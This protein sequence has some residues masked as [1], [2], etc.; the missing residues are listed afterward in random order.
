MLPALVRS[1]SSRLATRVLPILV[2]LGALGGAAAVQAESAAAQIPSPPSTI[3]GSISDSAGPVPAGLTVEAYVGDRLC[4]SRQTE[5][6][7]EPPGRVTVYSV[8]VVSAAQTAGCGTEGA[9]VRIKVGDRFA[10]QT[11][12]WREIG[13]ASCRERV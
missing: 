8:N 6:T 7:G 13:R 1:K 3:F 11:A 4:G 9:A 2:L 12:V 5:M 10:T